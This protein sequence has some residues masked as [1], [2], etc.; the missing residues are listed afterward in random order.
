MRLLLDMLFDIVEAAA[1]KFITFK[2]GE[3]GLLD[4]AGVQ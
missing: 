3:E 1:Y 4:C 2:P